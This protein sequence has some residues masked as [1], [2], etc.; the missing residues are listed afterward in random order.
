MTRKRGG[1]G[2]AL[3]GSKADGLVKQEVWGWT[4]GKQRGY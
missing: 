1:N 2:S 3:G 4:D